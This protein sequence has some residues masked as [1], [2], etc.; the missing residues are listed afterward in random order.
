MPSGQKSFR[1]VLPF[2]LN[3]MKQ[4]Y[5]VHTFLCICLMLGI[6]VKAARVVDDIN[7]EFDRTNKQAW[8]VKL[9]SG[10][11]SGKIVIPD[12][13][14]VGT[15]TF[16]VIGIG[17]SAFSNSNIT[18]I[19]LPET[20]LWIEDYAFM[21]C[22]KLTSLTLPDN[23]ERIGARAFEFCR[24]LEYMILPDK[25][26]IT[27][28]QYAF[29]GLSSLKHIAI[30]NSWTI[31]PAQLF[32]DI[33]ITMLSIGKNV[34][35]IQN[36][37][38]SGCSNLTDIYFKDGCVLDTISSR[39]FAGS[40]IKSMK[41]LP[42]S[43]RCLS[44]SAFADCPNLQEIY[45]PATVQ[46]LYGAE[47]KTQSTKLVIE[48]SPQ[49]FLYL[50]GYYLLN[51]TTLY[52][53]RPIDMDS[54]VI[55]YGTTNLKR[56]T[57][58]PY[59]EGGDEWKFG[60]NVKIIYAYM[61]HPEKVTCNFD[62]NV[63]DNAILYV[64]VGYMD[65]YMATENFSQ[66]FDVREFM[67]GIP[68]NNIEFE[69]I[70]TK[71]ECLYW[72]DKDYDSELSYKEAAA[73]TD[74]STTFYG[75]RDI[76]SF[77]EFQ[78]FTNV[79]SIPEKAFYQS[80]LTSIVFPEGITNIGKRAFY[81]CTKLSGSIDLPKEITAIEDWTFY[82]CRSLTEI[83]MS[84]Y[85]VERIGY[86]A[87]MYCEN[88]TSVNLP[89]GLTTIGESA[90]NMCSGLKDITLP[91]TISEIST[92]FCE[93]DNLKEVYCL[94]T[95]VPTTS[96]YAFN[97]TPIN[98]ATLYVPTASLELYRT[99]EPW[100]NF[101][102][103]VGLS[104]DII[105]ATPSI[106]GLAYTSYGP[107][108]RFNIPTQDENGN[109]IADSHLSFKL[110]YQDAAGYEGEVIFT[111]DCYEKLESDMTEISYG[112]TDKWDFYKNALYLNM[113]IDDW[114]SIG[115]QSI[116]HGGSEVALSDISW[117]S[118]IQP[119]AS[120]LP[121]DSD[122]IS[123]VFKG[124]DVDTETQTTIDG[125]KVAKVGD[126]IY[127]QGICSF[128]PEA[129]IKGTKDEDGVYIF[130]LGQFLGITENSQGSRLFV[131]LLGYDASGVTE[132]KMTYDEVT[133]IFSSTTYMLENCN[134]VDIVNYLKAYRSQAQLVPI[135][136][137]DAISQID[138]DTATH[139]RYNIAG[140]RVDKNYKGIIVENGRKFLRK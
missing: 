45:I 23:L 99:T 72:W 116:Y 123:Y 138:A 79:T 21:E 38:F 125:V 120:K 13:V 115:I 12:S 33:G 53:G 117:Y 111:T 86:G 124:I 58:G 49:P 126:D 25:D 41:I 44:A 15:S 112:F 39:A 132:F 5:I 43:V 36:S 110:Y 3:K 50:V 56:V 114:V 8:V 52:L 87:F 137:W 121:E 35:T 89:E 69:D 127:V 103:I 1:A 92:S 7:Y 94:A 97:N 26:G 51:P 113:D 20:L 6:N 64:P 131:F 104:G 83:N 48:D 27:F 46:T 139:V 77:D 105:P 101:G 80:D 37:A 91:S 93:C 32:Q 28:G 71:N 55:P 106:D 88:L 108:I 54:D 81:D 16:T 122:V 42:P 40:A 14:T 76:K 134:F 135:D 128:N 4:N 102:T 9:E 24:N 78:F 66:F 73:V 70:T 17:N 96:K 29:R 62:N 129:C 30:P 100:S 95:T 118:I 82:D 119:M 133:G 98:K 75:A 31:V 107:Y 68:V 136:D 10:N 140:Q 130:P 85:S 84:D 11:Y 109:T 61:E 90:F 22:E 47:L 65:A 2:F 74:I 34:R 67:P 18:S 60:K 19:T 59:F 57:F 63:Y